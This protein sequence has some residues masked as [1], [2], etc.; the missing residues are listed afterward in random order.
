MTA[1]RRGRR[2]CQL[3]CHPARTRLALPRPASGLATHCWLATPS[4]PPARPPRSLLRRGV[5]SAPFLSQSTSLP[6]PT[7]PSTAPR[8]APSSTASALAPETPPGP[9]ACR[10]SPAMSQTA[11][12]RELHHGREQARDGTS[13]QTKGAAMLKSGGTDLAGFP[14]ATSGACAVLALATRPQRAHALSRPKFPLYSTSAFRIVLLVFLTWMSVPNVS[15]TACLFFALT[16]C[17]ALW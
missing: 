15:A 8:R 9:G 1:P 2:C 4:A 14:A 17:E 13:E 6:S 5:H 11:P 7:Q 12:Q 3:R 10:P 16:V